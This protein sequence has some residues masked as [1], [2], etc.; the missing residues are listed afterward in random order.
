KAS[1]SSGTSEVVNGTANADIDENA[2][3]ALICPLVNHKQNG[4][5]AIVNASQKSSPCPYQ[6]PK[7]SCKAMPAKQPKAVPMIRIFAIASE[8]AKVIGVKIISIEA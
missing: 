7:I 5:I 6:L 1:F 4:P 3:A 8:P 2:I